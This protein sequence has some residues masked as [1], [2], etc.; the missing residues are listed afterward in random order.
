[1]RNIDY[2]IE[3]DI[4]QIRR[5]FTLVSVLWGI[6]FLLLM[7]VVFLEDFFVANNLDQ[8]IFQRL[9]FGSLLVLL[10]IN[11]TMNRCEVIGKGN[12]GAEYCDL[13]F[14]NEELHL[15]T[16]SVTLV[17]H[18]YKDQ[19]IIG[20]A[21]FHFHFFESGDANFLKFTHDGRQRKVQFLVGNKGTMGR[22]KKLRTTMAITHG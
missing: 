8:L 14:L 13:K 11:R 18:S 20:T 7:A 6:N 3:V 17:L 15:P 19:R 1:V 16:H 2:V 5:L 10:V 12:I 22:L 4:I 9:I 21:N